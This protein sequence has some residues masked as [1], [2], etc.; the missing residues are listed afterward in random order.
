MGHCWGGIVW[1]GRKANLSFSSPPVDPGFLVVARPG[2]RRSV[3]SLFSNTSLFFLS[4]FLSV[5]RV[6]RG[7]PRE[8]EREEKRV[9]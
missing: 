4:S 9:C 1:P 2:D 5:G 8:R 6:G 3:I 7:Q